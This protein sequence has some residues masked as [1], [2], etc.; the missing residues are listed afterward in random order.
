[1]ILGISGVII[2]V[3]WFMQNKKKNKNKNRGGNSQGADGTLVA[4]TDSDATYS[5]P[6]AR[7]NS[8]TSPAAVDKKIIKIESKFYCFVNN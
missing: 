1:M 6:E 2:G 5:E 8:S 3:W 7:V 4:K